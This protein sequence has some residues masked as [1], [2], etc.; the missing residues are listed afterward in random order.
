M[1]SSISKKFKVPLLLL[2]NNIH[3]L[4]LK[5]LKGNEN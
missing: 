2:I 3:L 5:M 1:F 4:E